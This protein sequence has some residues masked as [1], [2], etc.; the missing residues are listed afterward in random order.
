MFSLALILSSIRT[1]FRT[2]KVK[3]KI[4]K[5]SVAKCRGSRARNAW[6][7]VYVVRREVSSRDFVAVPYLWLFSK[8]E[9]H[10][11]DRVRP[12]ESRRAGSKP[13][14][15]FHDFPSSNALVIVHLRDRSNA[16]GE[17]RFPPE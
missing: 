10:S 4:Y 1:L 7:N 17:L 12:L 3:L 5:V 14:V 6:G 15:P 13:P 9:E 2:F 16:A 11:E 8:R